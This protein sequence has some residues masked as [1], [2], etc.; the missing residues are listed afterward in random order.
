MFL[1][2]GKYLVKG[3]IFERKE[4]KYVSRIRVLVFKF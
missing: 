1:D 3:V 2:I 4:I